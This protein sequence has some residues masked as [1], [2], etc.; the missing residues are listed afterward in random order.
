MKVLEA[1]ACVEYATRA[2]LLVRHACSPAV[3]ALHAGCLRQ[4]VLTARAHIAADAPQ[5][6]FKASC[7]GLS[8]LAG[9]LPGVDISNSDAL[10]LCHTTE[11]FL[12][13]AYLAFFS[14]WCAYSRNP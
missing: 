9:E 13:L 14:D 10:A 4:N 6:G 11:A 3:Q 7:I 2:L 8:K 12:R 1:Q 5:A